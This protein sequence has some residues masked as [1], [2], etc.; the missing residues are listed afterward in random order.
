[1]PR[2]TETETETERVDAVRGEE[3]TRV[4][5]ALNEA[6]GQV[7]RLFRRSGAEGSS[8]KK[9]LSTAQLS[10]FSILVDGGPM[11][12]GA[13]ALA[14]QVSK[15]TMSKLLA[16][17]VA[18]GLLQRFQGALGDRRVVHVMPTPEGE[19]AYFDERRARLGPLAG[20]LD[21]LPP[22]ELGDLGRA[23]DLLLR[24]MQPARGPL[25]RRRG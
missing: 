24:A 11:T 21:A 8:R 15:A 20:H 10:A 7:V 23:V 16:E 1:M 18:R 9:G 22:E 6:A 4:A 19:Q 25:V 12:V 13:L 14:E 17:M 3:L 5:E 2:E